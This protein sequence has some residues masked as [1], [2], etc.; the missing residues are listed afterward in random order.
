MIRQ[1][2]VLAYDATHAEPRFLLITSRSSKRWIIPRGNPIRGLAPALSAAQEAFEEAGLSG[3]V[4]PQ[5]IGTYRYRKQRRNGSAVTANVHVFPLQVSAQSDAW[6]ERDQ[7]ETRWFARTEAAAAVEE[8]AL[9]K[10]ILAFSPPALPAT[11]EEGGW[12][13]APPPRQSTLRRWVKS[14]RGGC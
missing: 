2:G 10:M 11:G 12:L 1:Y 9:K 14:L 3:L 7:R 4:A 8:P 13:P 5:E 6:P